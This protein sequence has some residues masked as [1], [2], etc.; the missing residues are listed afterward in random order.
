MRLTGSA[1]PLVLTPLALLAV[2]VAGCGGG[3]GSNTTST[4]SSSDS[5]QKQ[6]YVSQASEICATRGSAYGAALEQIGE[7]YK[8]FTQPWAAGQA[9]GAATAGQQEA[10]ALRGLEPPPALASRHKALVAAIAAAVRVAQQQKTAATNSDQARF[11][12]LDGKRTALENR[13]EAIAHRLG[14][15]TCADQLPAQDVAALKHVI[16]TTATHS[17]PAFC[18]RQFTRAFVHEQ[19]GSVAR[20]RREQQDSSQPTPRS[21]SVGRLFGAG[22]YATGTAAL[23]M[24][25]GKTQRVSVALLR[26]GGQW[27]MMGIVSQ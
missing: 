6:R 11:K 27:R 25:G 16:S 1:R 5:A 12:A 18:T 26:Q 19:F 4:S 14:L 9:A 10:A 15:P 24:P 23:T 13:G 17:D 8:P 22:D 21:A 2:A 3:G 7:S 20:C